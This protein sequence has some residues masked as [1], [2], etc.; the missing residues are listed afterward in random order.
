MTFPIYSYS[1]KLDFDVTI[2]EYRFDDTLKAQLAERLP[3]EKE[4]SN[5]APVPSF[6][7]GI[8]T[9]DGMEFNVIY[10]PHYGQLFVF[11]VLNADRA[12]AAAAFRRAFPEL[13]PL[14]GV[15]NFS[16]KRLYTSGQ[17][18]QQAWDGIPKTVSDRR[19]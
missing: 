11:G 4:D 2:L 16:K 18:R 6:A 7:V 5:F 13:D 12:I 15:V 14:E 9:D 10:L 8:R 1:K 19:K 3:F 17:K